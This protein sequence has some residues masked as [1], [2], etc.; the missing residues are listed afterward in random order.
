MKTKRSVNVFPYSL[1][2]LEPSAIKEMTVEN[3]ADAS[4][5]FEP[6]FDGVHNTA[7]TKTLNK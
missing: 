2:G 1:M 5:Y 6:K 4:P 3:L 7:R